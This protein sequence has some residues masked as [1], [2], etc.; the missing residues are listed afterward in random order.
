MMLE[1]ALCPVLIGR[2]QELSLLEDALLEAHRGSGRFV[3]LAGEAG[4]G[5]TRL[6]E[7]LQQ[8]AKRAGTVVMCGTCSEGELSLPYLPFLEAI[9][10]YLAG[11]DVERIKLRLGP[12]SCRQLGQLLPQL[13]LQTTLIDPGDPAQAKMRL[14]E[15][16]LALLRI[17]SERTGLLLVLEDLHWADS[18]T[19]QLL[20][21]MARRVRRARMLVLCTYRSDE[22]HRRHPLLP[23]VQAWQRAGTAQVIRLSPLPP[24]DVARMV[25]A[26]FE[27]A[28]VEA[29]LRD[30]LYA[31][32]EGNPFVLEEILKAALECGD[33]F[34]AAGGW[35]RKALNELS[36][37]PTVKDS[38]LL[39]VERLSE[40]QAEV[41]RAAAV[42]GRT[43]DYETLV[44]V[45]GKPASVVLAALRSLVQQQLMEE[46]R[47][48]RYRFRHA[49]TREVV[50]DDLIAP[51][52]QRLHLK[53]AEVLRSRPR[54]DAMEL[55]F[56]LLAAGE[57]EQA[58]PVALDAADDA[59]CRKGYAEAADLYE[60]VIDHVPEES[61]RGDVLGRLGRALFMAGQT[62]R[63]QRYLEEGLTILDRALDPRPAASY[64][65]LLGRCYWLQGR[66]D[67]A[68][69]E[70]VAAKQALEPFGPSED[71][72]YAYVRLSGL[73]TFNFENEQGLQLAQEAVRIAEAA[74][75]EAPGIWAY[76]FIGENLQAEGKP[77]EGLSWLD[78]SYREAAERGYDWIATNALGN[79]IGDYVHW[80]HAQQALERMQWLRALTQQTGVRDPFALHLDG[81][82]AMRVHGEPGRA[83]PLL[84]SALTLADEVGETLVARR[85]RVDLAYVWATLERMDLAW[86][87]FPAEPAST[88]RQ[89]EMGFLYTAM[90]LH[91]AEGNLSAAREKADRAAS[92]IT[93]R[94]EHYSEA[95]LLERTIDVL[96]QDDDPGAAQRLLRAAKTSH[97]AS[98]PLLWRARARVHLGSGDAR[99]ALDD[100]ERA[101]RTLREAAYND[102][103][104]PS[105]RLLAATFAALGDRG[106]AEAELR[107]VLKEAGDHGHVLEARLARNQ[108]RALGIEIAEPPVAAASS[109][110]VLAPAERVVTVMFVDVRGYTAMSLEQAPDAM[111][112]RIGTFYR[113]AEEE[114]RRHG[115]LVDR[116]AGDAVMA[117]FNVERMR[118]DHTAQALQ[119]ALAI[120]DKAAF[121]GLPVGIGIAVGP[122][123][124][125]QLS[126]ASPLTAVGETINLAARLQAQA[127]AGEVL[128]SA[129]AYRRTRSW[130]TDQELSSVPASLSLKGFREPVTAYR[131]AAQ[132]L[133]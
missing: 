95:H 4:M 58:I 44:G 119:A 68:K 16:L 84:E 37:P 124:V 72:A 35:E 65:L 93:E 27:G 3:V 19:R 47:S 97:I 133:A 63:G 115:G 98:H 67:L 78:R 66:P 109:A 40:E 39:R 10:N 7:E 8:R 127:G 59:E 50:H 32:T 94:P 101:A 34:R 49:L 123:V 53:A 86:Q 120:R 129:E 60:R 23:I 99:A 103:A 17:A 106:R 114:I 43:F 96:L 121:A 54:T 28:P 61:Q 110:E 131:L 83:R 71:L 108:L 113:W 76:T 2:Q 20:E 52:R 14:F 112:D 104:W 9:G 85:I 64:R 21:Y 48:G 82:L 132:A 77:D 30:F 92:L 1:R 51:E 88:E 80:G 126:E 41:L 57:W 89:E 56:H 105:R 25:S 100:A 125:G 33:I 118:L 46:E 6:A 18:S 122:A 87:L 70:Y 111:A 117:T 13:E 12:A 45:A 62:R 102:E 74:G 26:I 42:L 36:L 75:A 79:S 91:V 81:F 55:A 24:A 107:S 116:Y 128:L 69:R 22:L 29:E 130:L 38:I 31:R 11:A 73:H 15:A 5:K 90:F